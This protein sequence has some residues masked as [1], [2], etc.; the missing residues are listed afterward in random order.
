MAN[1]FSSSVLVD[2]YIYGPHGKTGNCILQCVDPK[3]GDV[4]WEEKNGIEA[5]MVADGKLIMINKSGELIVAEA[6]SSAYKEI[7]RAPVLKGGKMWTAPVLSNGLI[8]CRNSLGNM[9][10]LRVHK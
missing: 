3:T 10:C 5:L 6:H 2:G 4:Q 7:A 1:H 9:V 8:Y